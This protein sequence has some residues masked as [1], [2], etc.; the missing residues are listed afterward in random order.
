MV[1]VRETRDHVW[2]DL[3]EDLFRR[4]PANAMDGVDLFQNMLVGPHAFGNIF[5][6]L[7]NLL[8]KEIKMV[9]LG[10]NQPTLV[11]THLPLQ[12]LL[13]LLHLFT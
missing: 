2:P 5:V 12:G 13:K 3:D 6:Q 4:S 9:Q 10:F 7:R 1:R 8:S 11:G